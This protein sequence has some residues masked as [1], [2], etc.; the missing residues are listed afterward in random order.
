MDKAQNNGQV[1]T[2]VSEEG[3]SHL[4]DDGWAETQNHQSETSEIS[5]VV[6]GHVKPHLSEERDWSTE[7]VQ[8]LY[9]P[10]YDLSQTSCSQPFTQ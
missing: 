9:F 10:H 6:H 1:Q 2:T 4:T 5:Q 3:T 7:N 8:P